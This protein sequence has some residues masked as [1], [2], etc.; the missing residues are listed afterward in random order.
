[1]SGQLG[2]FILSYSAKY[3]FKMESTHFI[4]G[5]L[6]N[7][8]YTLPVESSW[9]KPVAGSYSKVHGPSLRVSQPKSSAFS[10]LKGLI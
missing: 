1:M 3:L 4:Y 6:F 8:V 9:R 10:R 5:R 7:F 2:A